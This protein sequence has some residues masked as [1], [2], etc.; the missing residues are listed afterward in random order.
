MMDTLILNLILD[1]D[2]HCIPKRYLVFYDGWEMGTV[3]ELS[4]DLARLRG[5]RK[6]QKKCEEQFGSASLSKISVFEVI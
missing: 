5:L 1:E 4:E 2:G 3:V 6:Y